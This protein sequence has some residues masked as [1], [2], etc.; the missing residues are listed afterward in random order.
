MKNHYIKLFNYDNWATSRLLAAAESVQNDPK[1]KDLISHVITAN[2]VWLGRIKT[3]ASSATAWESRDYSDNVSLF[4]E[5]NSNWQNWLGSVS[6]T[7]LRGLIHYK[8][9]K[10]DPFSGVLKDILTHVI[11]HSTYHRG[12]IATRLKELGVQVPP[13][14]FIVYTREEKK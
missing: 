6:E 12:Q 2:T 11:N 7:D 14:D 8:N 9:I 10:G 4:R 1:L 3:D 13:T 5:N